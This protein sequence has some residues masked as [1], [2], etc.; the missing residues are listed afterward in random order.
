MM[1]ATTVL[2]MLSLQLLIGAL[3]YRAVAEPALAV[4]LGVAFGT[5][6]TVMLGVLRLI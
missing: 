6:F 2:F 1:P 4:M 3:V 5:L